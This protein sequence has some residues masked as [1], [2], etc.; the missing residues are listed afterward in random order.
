MDATIKNFSTLRNLVDIDRDTHYQ[1]IIATLFLNA[2]NDWDTPNL[3]EID[4]FIDE[5]KEYFG[6]PLVID[7]IQTKK[8][9]EQNAWKIEAGSSI[10]ELIT[11][12]SKFCNQPDFDEIVAAILGYYNSQFRKVD[13]IA[14]LSYFTTEQGGRSSAAMSGYRPQVKFHFTEK[15]TS[16]QQIFID[17]ELVYP[18]DKVLAKIKVIS[19]HYFK[20][21][22]EEGILFEFRE[23]ATVIGIGKVQKIINASLEK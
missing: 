4:V 18:G 22:L 9:E 20:G 5:L 23:G 12:S 6:T 3:T 11:F 15:Q 10:I 13:F 16:G 8:L 19:P 21:K 14:E 17:K 2:V 7:N 1:K